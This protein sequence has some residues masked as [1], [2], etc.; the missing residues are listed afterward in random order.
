MDKEKQP[1][2]RI[3][4]NCRYVQHIGSDT[5]ETLLCDFFSEKINPVRIYDTKEQNKK[6]NW[7]KKQIDGKEMEVDKT[8][9]KNGMEVLIHVCPKQREPKEIEINELGANIKIK[10]QPPEDDV[11][12]ANLVYLLRTFYVDGDFGCNKFKK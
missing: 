12:Q 9:A 11:A 6:T 1:I 5:E 4:R 8:L 10:I 2:E 7:I 3:C